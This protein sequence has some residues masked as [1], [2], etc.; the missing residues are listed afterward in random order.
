MLRVGFKPTISVLELPKILRAFDN[1]GT[2]MDAS[3]LILRKF[4]PLLT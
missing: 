4:V 3:Y 2:M 1:S